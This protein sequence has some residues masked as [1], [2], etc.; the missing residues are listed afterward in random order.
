LFVFWTLQDELKTGMEM[1]GEVVD[2]AELDS[3][4]ALADVDRNGKIDYGGT[5]LY[6]GTELK[7]TR[8][9]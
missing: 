6:T 2:D 9:T 1:M 8:I 3:L 4:I 7:S 5:T